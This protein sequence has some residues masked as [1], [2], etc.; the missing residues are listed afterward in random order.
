MVANAMEGDPALRNI[1]ANIFA[2]DPVP[3]PSNF[4]L[5]KV[6]LDKNV[7]EIVSFFRLGRTRQRLFVCYSQDQFRYSGH[8]FSNGRPS[9]HFGR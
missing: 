8:Y 4:Q 6:A 7:K 9:R 2:V 5:E 3:G 1:P